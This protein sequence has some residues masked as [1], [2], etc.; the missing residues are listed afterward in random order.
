MLFRSHK[1]AAGTVSDVR[2]QEAALARPFPQGLVEDGRVQQGNPLHSEGG[3]VH[4]GPVIRDDVEFRPP[5]RPNRV[6]QPAVGQK[7]MMEDVAVL[8]PLRPFS[9]KYKRVARGQQSRPPFHFTAGLPADLV[10]TPG[11][12]AQVVEIGRASCRERV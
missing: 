7:A 8:Q 11:L 10:E 4:Q 9:L 2:R 3:M 6:R 1:T 12:S 5:E